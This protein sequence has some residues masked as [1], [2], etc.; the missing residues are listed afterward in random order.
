M[1]ASDIHIVFSDFK[2]FLSDFIDN[3]LI[4]HSVGPKNL[5]LAGKISTFKAKGTDS[6]INEGNWVWFYH[7]CLD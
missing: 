4:K 2:S 5:S 1:R 3:I 7:G 6:E